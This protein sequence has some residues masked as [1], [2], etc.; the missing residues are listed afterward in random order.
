MAISDQLC[1]SLVAILLDRLD[2]RLIRSQCP[3][4][5]AHVGIHDLQAVNVARIDPAEPV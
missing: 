3:Q 4:G 5:S 2:E 1:K